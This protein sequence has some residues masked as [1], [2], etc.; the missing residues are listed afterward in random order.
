M[1]KNT[2]QRIALRLP[3]ADFNALLKIAERDDLSLSQL[4]RRAIRAFLEK[5]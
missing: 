2:E 3:L 1:E 5:K 4:V